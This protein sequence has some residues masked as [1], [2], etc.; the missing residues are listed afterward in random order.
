M[1]LRPIYAWS[2]VGVLILSGCQNEDRKEPIRTRLT[3]GNSKVNQNSCQIISQGKVVRSQVAAAP[4]ETPA[5]GPKPAPNRQVPPRLADRTVEQCLDLSKLV[6]CMSALDNDVARLI[7]RDIRLFEAATPD[8]KRDELVPVNDQ[9]LLAQLLEMEGDLKL[10][11]EFGV[12][13]KRVRDTMEILSNVATQTKCEEVVIADSTGTHLAK[14]EIIKSTSTFLDMKNKLNNE[15]LMVKATS[16]QRVLIQWVRP[17]S[18]TKVCG[19]DREFMV[20]EAIEIAVGKGVPGNV[21]IS[22][23]IA[24]IIN[25]HTDANVSLKNEI[26]AR[27]QSKGKARKGQRGEGSL[28]LDINV[29]LEAYSQVRKGQLKDTGCSSSSAPSPAGTPATRF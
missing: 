5:A 26:K 15:W 17:L 7:T 16:P 10:R 14:Y 25:A 6:K 20:S 21:E 24:Q 3:S 19:V 4:G 28:S 29:V 13:L 27:T 23:P 22:Q 8:K 12:R 2:I 1:V 11:A 9:K 18:K